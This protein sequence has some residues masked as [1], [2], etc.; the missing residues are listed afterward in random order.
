M[1]IDDLLSIS[2]GLDAILNNHEMID[3]K[4]SDNEE[5][6]AEETLEEEEKL[7]EAHEWIEALTK[8]VTFLSAY[9]IPLLLRTLRRQGRRKP[10]N[11]NNSLHI[12][13]IY[14]HQAQILFSGYD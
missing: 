11:M 7:D 6:A 14:S 2:P 4:S 12:S 1:D 3:L 13:Q 8:D 5:M 9:F 10:I